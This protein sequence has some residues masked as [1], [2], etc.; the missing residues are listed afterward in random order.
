MHGHKEL[1]TMVVMKIPTKYI[2][3][4]MRLVHPGSNKLSVYLD[5]R[6]SQGLVDIF[7]E[8]SQNY[9]STFPLKSIKHWEKL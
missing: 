4:G 5:E 9:Q 8:M 6:T 2:H 1:F 7:Q 3:L